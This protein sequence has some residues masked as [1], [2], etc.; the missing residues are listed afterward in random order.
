MALLRTIRGLGGCDARELARVAS[1]VD[2]ADVA[3]GQVLTREG[4]PA[5]EAFAIV[6]GWARVTL[7][8][9]DLGERG[10]GDFIGEMAMLERAPRS[11]TVVATTP[12][13]LLVIGPA[14]FASFLECPSVSRALALQL[15]RR[16]RSCHAMGP[17]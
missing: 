15:A 5:R 9:V 17:G 2:V 6:A 16:L 1:H 10:P 8:G 4:A 11:A 3:A 14:A 13:R 12:M 7:R